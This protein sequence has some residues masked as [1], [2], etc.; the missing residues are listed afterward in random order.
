MDTMTIL[1]VHFASLPTDIGPCS[2]DTKTALPGIQVGRTKWH[3]VRTLSLGWRKSGTFTVLLHLAV[4]MNRRNDRTLS[5][6]VAK[7]GW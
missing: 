6:G 7:C 1:I 3:P 5:A 2:P 4:N